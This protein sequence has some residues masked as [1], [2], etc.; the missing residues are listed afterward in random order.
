MST[1][2]L[3]KIGNGH[4]YT[5]VIVRVQELKPI[6]DVMYA[7]ERENLIMKNWYRVTHNST[8]GLQMKCTLK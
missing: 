8:K 1:Y 7:N 6:K 2:S 5:E 3:K 4:Y